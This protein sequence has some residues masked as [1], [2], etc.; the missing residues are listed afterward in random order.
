MVGA[1]YANIWETFSRKIRRMKHFAAPNAKR[2]ASRRHLVSKLIRTFRI[3][4]EPALL[5]PFLLLKN[6]FD[7]PKG[8]KGKHTQQR[9]NQNMVYI[10]RSR[11][12]RQ[13]QQQE[14]PPAASAAIV[15][16]LDHNG[17][18]HA[19]NQ[20]RTDADNESRQMVFIQKIH[21]QVDKKGK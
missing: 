8:R 1:K 6:L 11:Y 2:T 14:S 20:K 4:G 18:E 3:L 12:A 15:F 21:V 19:D 5:Y 16:G 17:M 10:H 9:S 7:G 13:A